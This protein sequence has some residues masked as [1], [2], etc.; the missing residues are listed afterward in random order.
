M[1]KLLLSALLVTTACQAASV[2]DQRCR[3]GYPQ[4]WWEK[5]DDPNARDWEILPHQAGDCEVILSK[6]NELGILSNFAPT[7]IKIDGKRYASLEG[8][9]QSL[10]FPENSRDE[11]AQAPGV[12]WKL[13]RKQVEQMTGFEAKR[14][15]KEGS[16]NMKKLGINWVTYKGQRMIYR[17][18]KKGKHYEL[19]VRAMR[20][21]LKQNPKVKA[22][23]EQTGNLTLKPDH[24]Q[25]PNTPPAWKYFE[26]WQELRTEL[27]K[28]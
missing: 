1:L 5:I 28:L 18:L 27:K 6:R 9:W 23:L 15:G 25:K 11:R 7:P 2:K 4:H 17:T 16:N 8:F 12:E 22:I 21:K 20:A 13:T 3:E 19:I 10:K 24:K 14:A 26:I